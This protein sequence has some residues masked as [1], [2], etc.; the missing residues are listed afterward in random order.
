MQSTRKH[1]SRASPD[2]GNEETSTLTIIVN[3]ESEDMIMSEVKSKELAVATTGFTA[4]A[5]NILLE[6]AM[7]DE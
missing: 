2:H 6:E 5:N 1:R 7:T 4:L 3:K